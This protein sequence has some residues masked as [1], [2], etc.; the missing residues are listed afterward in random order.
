[1]FERFTTDAREVVVEAQAHARRL[2][3]D[4][5][6]CEHLLL[7]LASI[8][9]Q[10]ATVL[11]G[12]GATPA[13]LEAAVQQLIGTPDAALDREAL[14]AIGIDLDAVREKVE[15]NFGP[16]AL[17]PTLR[18][19]RRWWGRRAACDAT[20]RYGHIP[21]TPRAAKCLQ[22]SLGEAVAL[23]HRHIGMEHIALALTTMTDG[24]APQ[25]LFATGSSPARLRTAILNRHRQAS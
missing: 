6:G 9:G 7:A 21:F 23:G 22:T 4:Y 8:E 10:I 1:M 24:I 18:P 13:A 12:L 25:L 20:P 19:R 11:H 3:H 17:A 5:I 14:A 2:G 16:R 15:A